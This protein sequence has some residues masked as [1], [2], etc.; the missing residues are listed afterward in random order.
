LKGW[1]GKLLNHK[2]RITRINSVVTSTATYFLTV[3]PPDPWLIKKFNTLRRNFLW[4]PE[5]ER[6]SGGKCIVNWKKICAPVSYGGLGIK[7]WG[8]KLELSGCVGNG[9]DGLIRADHG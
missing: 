7:I 2:G 4:A 6:V 5:E 1:K 8:P 9:F 3:F